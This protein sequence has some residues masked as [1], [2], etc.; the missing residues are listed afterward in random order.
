MNILN[1]S[2]AKEDIKSLLT[3]IGR[4]V[5]GGLLLLS[6]TLPLS[7]CCHKK[8]SIE[9]G[10]LPTNQSTAEKFEIRYEIRYPSYYMDFKEVGGYLILAAYTWPVLMA[11]ARIRARKPPAQLTVL[12]LE[13]L[14]C[15]GSWWLIYQL[16]SFGRR[17]IGGYLALV[18]VSLYFLATGIDA[19][20]LWG[21]VRGKRPP[22]SRLQADAPHC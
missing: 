16:G 9:G 5:A 1:P 4:Y 19:W 7:Q 11:F 18:G 10:K 14:L 12:I 20:I 2:S 15:A 17:L 3:R 22:T 6:L 13:A 8:C 21:S